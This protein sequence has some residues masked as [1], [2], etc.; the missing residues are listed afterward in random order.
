MEM[1]DEDEMKKTCI[2]ISVCRFSFFLFL[3]KYLSSHSL[4][5]AAA[6]ANERFGLGHMRA[7]LL[8]WTERGNPTISDDH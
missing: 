2:I 6:A 3:L 7:Q 5:P 1:E 8:K 4:T